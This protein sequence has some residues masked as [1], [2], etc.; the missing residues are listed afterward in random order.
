MYVEG[1]IYFRKGSLLR[2]FISLYFFLEIME[3]F[4]YNYIIIIRCL[5]VIGNCY[6]LFGNYEEV[7]KFYIKVYD[8]RGKFLGVKNY[9]DLLFFKG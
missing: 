2:V 9:L 3:D 1:E 8:M 4:L 6:N 5:N 7:L